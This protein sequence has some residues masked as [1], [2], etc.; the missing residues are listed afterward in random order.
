MNLLLGVVEGLREIQAHKFRSFLTMLGVVLGVASLLAMFAMTAGMTAGFQDMLTQVGGLERVSVVDAPVPPAQELMKDASPG[1]TYRDAETIRKNATLIRSVSPELAMHTKVTSGS[2][3]INTRVIGVEDPYFTI[4]RHTID[5][6]RLLGDL[7]HLQSKPVCVIGW[8]AANEL[9][10]TSGPQVIGEKIRIQGVLFTV[11]GLFERYETESQKRTRELGLAPTQPAPKGNGRR[12]GFDPLRWKNMV[13]AI[14]HSTFFQLYR[15]SS[16]VNNVDQGPNKKLDSLT[17]EIANVDEFE[18]AL[19]QLRNIMLVTHNSIEDFAFDTK[20]SW[21]ESVQ[22]A[23]RNARIS[24]GVIAGISLLVGAIGICNIML[25]SISERIREIGIRRAVGAKSRDIFIQI[26][27]ESCVLAAIGG[28]LGLLAT[29]G[30]LHL[31]TTLVPPDNA[32]II[33]PSA[34]IFS[35]SSAVVAG[36]LAGIYPAW[37]AASLN[38]IEA[39]RYE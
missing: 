37:K 1:R 6:G 4:E 24:G 38:P 15:S 28:V 29:F 34:V 23:S 19:E 5:H 14:P 35:L 21:F 8:Q 13:V 31:I 3:F 17:V 12:G 32:P 25:A 36:M 20:E 10:R 11:V 33:E 26:I 18:D 16:I 27:V 22:R 39:L 2:K 30:L 7:D 9:F